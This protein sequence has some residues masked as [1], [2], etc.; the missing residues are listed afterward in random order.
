M[1][2][3]MARSSDRLGRTLALFGNEVEQATERS[4]RNL[5]AILYSTAA[6]TKMMSG[7]SREYFEFAQREIEA[8]TDR[9]NDLRR[10]RIPQ[11]LAVVNIDFVRDTIGRAFESG[12]RT[13]DMFL[14]AADDTAKQVAQEKQG[15]AA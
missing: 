5:E 8:S 12:R 2:A 13:T 15:R 9:L 14:K 4:A 10:S 7:M 1:M 11:E 6:S 3:M